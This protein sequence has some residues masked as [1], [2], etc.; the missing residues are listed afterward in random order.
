MKRSEATTLGLVRRHARGQIANHNSKARKRAGHQI[1]GNKICGVFLKT[2]SLQSGRLV[3]IQ[4]TFEFSE[5]C[6]YRALSYL[7]KGNDPYPM[8]IDL[9][10]KSHRG[11]NEIERTGGQRL[12]GGGSSRNAA[13]PSSA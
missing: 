7:G 4:P 5:Q 6:L 10:C 11:D 8:V 3:E 13:V 1:T 12:A 2:I 9:E